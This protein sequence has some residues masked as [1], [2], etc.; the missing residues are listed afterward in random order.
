MITAAAYRDR[1]I[2]HDLQKAVL[3]H[4][5]ITKRRGVKMFAVPNAGR[6]SLR[7]G[8][9]MKAEGLTAGVADLCIMLPLGRVAW[10]EMKTAKGRQSLPQKAFQ[11][12]CMAL[13]HPY[14][15]ARTF[16]QAVEFLRTVG[17]LR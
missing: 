2:E 1:V 11:A 4:F 10:L 6:R 17:A 12:D 13:G 14:C 5:E 3:Q 16:D 7:M 8:A 9:R 15:L